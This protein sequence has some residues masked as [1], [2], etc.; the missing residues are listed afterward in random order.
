MTKTKETPNLARTLA[1]VKLITAAENAQTTQDEEALGQAAIAYARLADPVFRDL[2]GAAT[3]A[4][5]W[6]VRLG[7]FIGNG[8]GSKPTGR[9]EAIGALRDAIAK[10]QGV[11]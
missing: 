10:V 4:I 7:D 3:E 5:P 8:E 9:C 6:L 2:L 11:Q 1:M